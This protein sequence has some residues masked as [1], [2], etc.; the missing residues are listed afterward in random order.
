ML[1]QQQVKT[2]AGNATLR[3]F[4]SPEQ[5]IEWAKVNSRFVC[6]SDN[7]WNRGI[8]SVAEFGELLVRGEPTLENRVKQTWADFHI[9]DTVAPLNKITRDVAGAFPCVPSYLAG[10]PFCMKRRAPVIAPS[11]VRIFASV[12]TSAYF[13]AEETEK[14]GCIIAALVYK[15]AQTRPVTLYVTDESAVSG[16]NYL[17]AIKLATRPMNLSRIAT[18]LAHPATQRTLMFSIASLNNVQQIGWPFNTEPFKPGAE[19]LYREGYGLLKNDLFIPG[20]HMN[21]PIR[22]N[23]KAWLEKTLKNFESIR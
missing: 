7:A 23:P 1:Q 22:D 9:S 17:T 10:D 21:D 5:A 6:Q 19:G 14:R 13:G 4:D 3:T 20:L 12:A 11:P 16:V 8:G 15:L 2:K 18:M